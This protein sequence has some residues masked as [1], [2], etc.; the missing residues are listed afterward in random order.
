[1]S[2]KSL[3]WVYRVKGISMSARVVLSYLAFAQNH[4]TGKC[5]SSV[6]T[7]VDVCEISRASVF[8]A[9]EELK[10]AGLITVQNKT[11]KG[12]RVANHFV[13]HTDTFPEQSHCET[14]VSHSE[15]VVSHC[16]TPLEPGL[17]PVLEPVLKTAMTS[18]LPIDSNEDEDSEV[19]E[20]KILEIIG[21][22]QMKLTEFMN[23]VTL[24]MTVDQAVEKAKAKKGHYTGISLEILWKDLNVILKTGKFQVP[25]T[26]KQRGQFGHLAKKYGSEDLGDIGSVMHIA[27][28][29]WMAFGKFLKGQGLVQDFPDK[30]EIGFFLKWAEMGFEFQKSQ[31]ASLKAPMGMKMHVVS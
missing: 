2:V 19:E 17:E 27:M 9:L 4:K 31:A 26:Q 15:T 8:R 5:N 16:E 30:P 25:M 12:W 22:E 7:I 14:V 3:N 21:M 20:N 10:T 13:L 6:G 11:S 24:S 18:S 29:D 1:M 28:R 23:E